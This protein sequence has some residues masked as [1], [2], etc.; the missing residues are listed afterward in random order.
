MFK[1]RCLPCWNGKE[2]LFWTALKALIS[3]SRNFTS[4]L[5]N[6]QA[7]RFAIVFRVKLPYRQSDKKNYPCHWHV[8]VSQTNQLLLFGS[9]S[10]R[11]VETHKGTRLEGWEGKIIR[12]GDYKGEKAATVLS[13]SYGKKGNIC[14]FSGQKITFH[15]KKSV[16]T[17]WRQLRN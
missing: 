12:V 11:A 16:Q 5:Y 13:K 6:Y 8:R 17:R 4:A 14:E 10:L 9:C 3:I 15:G 7:W 1:N 2:P